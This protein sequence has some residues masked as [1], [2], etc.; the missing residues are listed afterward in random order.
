MFEW[1]NDESISINK[2]LQ[3]LNVLRHQNLS[4]VFK[5]SETNIENLLPQKKS[6]IIQGKEVTLPKWYVDAF[7][8]SNYSNLDDFMQ[9]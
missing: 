9:D 2:S 1:I 4:M 3:E 7:E 5:D 8:N 6:V